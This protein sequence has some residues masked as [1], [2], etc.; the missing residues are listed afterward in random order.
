MRN[1]VVLLLAAL[2][3]SACAGKVVLL[4]RTAAV[5]AG[6]DLS[7]QWRLQGSED[8]LNRARRR[9]AQVFVFLESGESLK[10]TQTPHGLFVSFDRA[11]VEEYRFGENRE[12]NIG[13]VAAQRVSGWDGAAY[14]IETL[15]KDGAVLSERYSIEGDTL[16]RRI[17][18]VVNAD[19]TTDL[20]QVFRRR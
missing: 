8:A 17:R 2:L 10:V 1:A 4:P 13:P 19:T 20:T 7:G 12:I 6:V 9:G 11:I 3:L 18:V 5:P 15:D 14:V 16:L